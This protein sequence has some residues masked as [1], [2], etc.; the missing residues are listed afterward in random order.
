MNMDKFTPGNRYF[1]MK[2]ALESKNIT[3]ACKLLGISSVY[4][5]LKLT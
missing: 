5:N 3:K 1:V 2:Y 4:D